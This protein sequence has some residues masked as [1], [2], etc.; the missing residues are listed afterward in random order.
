MIPHL[1]ILT[2]TEA[3][4]AR[5]VP[6][7]GE[8][9]TLWQMPLVIL[10]SSGAMYGITKLAPKVAAYGDWTKRLLL[11]VVAMGMSVAVRGVGGEVSADLGTLFWTAADGL[12]ST[13]AAGT[14]FRMAKV[15][16]GNT[17]DGS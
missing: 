2:Q 4:V 7:L 12:A 3:A 14:V 17:G 10:L 11:L 1:H 8:F 15:Q 6:S 5:G 9:L 13:V 16:T